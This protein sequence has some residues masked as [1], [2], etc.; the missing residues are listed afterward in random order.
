MRKLN[1]ETRRP[2]GLSLEDWLGKQFEQLNEASREDSADAAAEAFVFDDT[3]VTETVTFDPASANATTVR[4]VLSTLLM[5]LRR[6][7]PNKTQ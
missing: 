4:N 5:Y 3:A 6:G 2:P 1:L 7:A